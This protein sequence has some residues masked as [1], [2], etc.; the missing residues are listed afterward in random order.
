[1]YFGTLRAPVKVFSV[2][3]L[4]LTNEMKTNLPSDVYFVD[5]TIVYPHLVTPDIRY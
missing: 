5:W 4:C 2:P 3:H 1:M